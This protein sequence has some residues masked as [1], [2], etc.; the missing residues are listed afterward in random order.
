MSQLTP[1][2]CSSSPEHDDYE[3]PG[4]LPLVD[5]CVALAD[6]ESRLSVGADGHDPAHTLVE[7][8]VQ[9]RLAHGVYSLE[10]AH[11]RDVE[12]LAQTTRTGKFPV[13]LSRRVCGEEHI[14]TN[15]V[16]PNEV[17]V[18]EVIFTVS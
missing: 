14:Y 9:R 17:N 7:V 10:L 5:E 8:A 3:I 12:A 15:E 6:K 16:S 11:G 1:S 18:T 2:T 13:S 4:A